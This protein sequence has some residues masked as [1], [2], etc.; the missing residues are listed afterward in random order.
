MA[1]TKHWLN[2]NGY[3][4]INSRLLGR[5]RQW[6]IAVAPRA[7][8]IGAGDEHVE[9]TGR[10][11]GCERRRP[12]LLIEVAVLDRGRRVRGKGGWLGHGYG[13]LSHCLLLRPLEG[14]LH[15]IQGAHALVRRGG[16]WE[17]HELQVQH[18]VVEEVQR[19]LLRWREVEV[20]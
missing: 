6:H 11:A 17:G 19:L 8:W 2:S 20:L 14:G 3:V 9:E 15:F 18:L 16:R 4:E 1:P 5:H 7:L 13:A 12:L 10:A